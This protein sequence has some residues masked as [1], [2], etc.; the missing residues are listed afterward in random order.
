MNDVVD[1]GD[2]LVLSRIVSGDISPTA[3][4]L[5]LGDLN[6]N[7]SLDAGDQVLMMRVLQ[8]YIDMP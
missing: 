3:I 1:L 2:Y 8:G 6:L 4:H 5:T 7:G